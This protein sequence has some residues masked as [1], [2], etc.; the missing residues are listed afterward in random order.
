VSL[1]VNE[2]VWNDLPKTYQAIIE[3]ASRTAHVAM[4]ARYDALN[5]AALR[6]LIAAGAQ[7]R[8]FPRAVM[9]ASWDAANKVYAEFAAKDPKFKAMYEN[10]MGYRD[11]VVPWFRVAE[12]SYDQY[13][14]TALG[15]GSK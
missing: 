4:T 2:S 12:G 1:Y 10:Y 7:L 11:E 8:A 6:R 3:A 9:D 15:R 5:A 14:S 13:L